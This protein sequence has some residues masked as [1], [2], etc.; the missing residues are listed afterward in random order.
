M[1]KGSKS[2]YKIDGHEIREKRN[3]PMIHVWILMVQPMDPKSHFLQHTCV[4]RDIHVWIGILW[5]E[6]LF[7]LISFIWS[8]I[9]KNNIVFRNDSLNTENVVDKSKFRSYGHD[10]GWKTL[11][12]LL[13]S[14]FVHIYI[15]LFLCF[16][17]WCV[18]VYLL[19]A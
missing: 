2:C 5:H 12:S 19:Y 10:A 11:I 16:C 4:N 3:K 14:C 1:E 17:V 6:G 7:C 18:A 13:W 8:W 15:T 9:H